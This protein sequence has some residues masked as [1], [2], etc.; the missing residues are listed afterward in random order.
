MAIKNFT[1]FQRLN[2][3]AAGFLLVISMYFIGVHVKT[4]FSGPNI[5]L[6][7]TSKINMADISLLDQLGARAAI[8]VYKDKQCVEKLATKIYS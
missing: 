8:K 4:I 3:P 1:G 6:K 5:I 2:L 7:L